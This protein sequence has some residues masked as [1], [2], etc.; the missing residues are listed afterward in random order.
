MIHRIQL[1]LL[2]KNNN[3]T[4]PKG[5]LGVYCYLSFITTNCYRFLYYRFVFIYCLPKAE[6]T[7]QRF[8]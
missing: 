5:S 1:S 6:C 8:L 4:K 3:C 2:Y 7:D